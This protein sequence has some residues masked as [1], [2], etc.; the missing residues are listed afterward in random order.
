MLFVIVQINSDGVKAVL[1]LWRIIANIY[2]MN[3]RGE[4]MNGGPPGWWLDE[5][6]KPPFRKNKIIMLQNVTQNLRLGQIF[7]NDLS[8]GKCS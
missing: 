4:L 2:I 1:R 3:S 6:T 7:W 8:K 5:E